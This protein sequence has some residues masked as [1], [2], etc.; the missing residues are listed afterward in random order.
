MKVTRGSGL[1]EGLLAKKRAN[2]ANN[3]IG[4]D[5]RKGRI[6]DAGCG[7]F[8]YFLSTTNFKEKYGLDPVLNL[9]A[10]K[11]ANIRLTKASIGKKRLPF[12]DNFFNVV[13]M[14]AVFE[15]IEHNNLVAVIKELRRVLKKDGMLIITTPAP[16]ADKLLHQMAKVS[17]ISSEEIHEHKHNHSKEKIGDII[18]DGG[19]SKSK[20]RSGFFELGMNMWF[21]ARK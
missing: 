16:W 11:G 1:F 7:S 14:L 17:L 13:T 8:P 12:E 18:E 6:L 4:K 3:L 15:H 20:I 2:L 10:V 19:F 21:V 5:Q 9:A